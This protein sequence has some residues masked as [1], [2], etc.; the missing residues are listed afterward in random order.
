MIYKEIHCWMNK[1]LLF[2]SFTVIFPFQSESQVISTTLEANW[3]YIPQ[4][5]VEF[6]KPFLFKAGIENWFIR[7]IALGV[8]I[9]GGMA[10]I[11]DRDYISVNGRIISEKSLE[12]TNIIS[13]LNLYTKIAIF[14]GDDYSLSIKPEIGLYW[15][16]SMPTISFIDNLTKDIDIRQYSRI[17]RKSLSFGLGIQGQYF[18]T[19]RWDLCL[20]LGYNNYNFGKSLNRID[21]K[22]E[23]SHGFNEKTCFLSAGLG[24]HYY[25]FGAGKR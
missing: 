9:Q 2:F 4:N 15:A 3:V 8:N 19:E 10:S 16:E 11:E 13:S 20:N 21:L 18:I 14:S 12:I 23:W 25:L 6:K 22:G 1:L 24:F 7:R 5:P 17:N